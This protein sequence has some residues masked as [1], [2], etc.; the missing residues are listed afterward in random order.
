M[1]DPDKRLSWF[2]SR[3]ISSTMGLFGPPGA[4]L[5]LS[6]QEG[7]FLAGAPDMTGR[8]FTLSE[9]NG[10]LPLVR[11]IAR[12]AVRCY[13]AAK[14]EIRTW[15]W[16]RGQQPSAEIE[17]HV[18]RRDQHIARHLEDLRRLTEELE[19]L[20][21]HLRDFERGVVDFPASCLGNGPFVFYC[22]ALGEDRVLH[23]RDEEEAFEERHLV[24][25][26]R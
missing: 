8:L 14:R 7:R 21:C 26:P 16:L 17:A 9:A 10:V 5:R 11:S 2:Q 1:G 24:A 20:G 6:K 23:W 4:A 3:N 15:E 12:D 13:R 25:V 18:A 22:W 19:S